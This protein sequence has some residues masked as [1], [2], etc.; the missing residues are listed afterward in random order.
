MDLKNNVEWKFVMHGADRT[1]CENFN[2]FKKVVF[3]E[4]IVMIH[5][6]PPYFDMQMT[7]KTWQIKPG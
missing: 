1:D 4:K 5:Q 7:F 3:Y 6:G 2:I